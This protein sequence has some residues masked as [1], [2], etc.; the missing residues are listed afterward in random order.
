MTS[1]KFELRERPVSGRLAKLLMLKNLQQ[2]TYQHSLK[3]NF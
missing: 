2:Q 3:L 1:S